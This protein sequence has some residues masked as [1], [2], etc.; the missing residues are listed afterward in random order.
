MAGGAGTERP[1]A[2]TLIGIGAAST[3]AHLGNNFTTYLVGGLIDRFGFSPFAMGAWNMAETLSYAG[4]MFLIAPRARQLDARV[5]ALVASVLVVVSQGGSALTGSFPL[6]FAGRIGTG[7]GFGII[8]A[9]VNLAAGR[10]SHPARWISLGIAF[11]TVLFA[12][13]A[14]GLPQVGDSY[15]VT[16]MFAALAAISAVLGLMAMLLPGGSD[17][18]ASKLHMPNPPIGADGLRVLTAMALFAFGTLAL[19]PFIERTAHAIGVPATE[20]GR[21]QSLATLA[22]ALGNAGLAAV[23]ARL[24]RAVPMAVVLGA[25]GVTCALLTTV[26][27]APAF[28]AAFIGYYVSWFLT[29]P[30]LLG[31]AFDCDKS[32][33]LAVMTTGTW[34]LAQSFGSLAAGAIAQFFG[35][36]APIGPLGALTC[37]AAI[38][39]AWPLARRFDADPARNRTADALPSH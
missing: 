15:G 25:C 24:T 31:L 36:Y 7:L 34:L 8:N 27:S 35:G 23:T 9:A 18:Q 12:G 29:Y 14:L 5:L 17:A 20:F 19:W 6:L 13:I 1:F 37:V 39:V 22:S 32:G 28:A 21:Y 33:R 4:A 10:T 3:A 26:G 16:G 30:M 38:A 2:F 11:Q